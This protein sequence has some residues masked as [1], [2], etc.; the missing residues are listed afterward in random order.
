M[1]QVADG[2]QCAHSN[3]VVHRDVKPANIRL[4]PDG[5]VKILDFG[6]ARVRRDEKATR[7]TQQGDLIGTILYMSPE[8]FGGAD[9]DALCDIFAYGV[10]Y[11]EFLTGKH[12]FGSK[13]P[14]S[15]MFKITMEDPPSLRTII[16]DCPEALDRLLHR[17]LHKD[18]ELRYQNLGDLRLDA[19]P[20]IF[21][22]RQAR[23][24][25]LV[26][27]AQRLIE[28]RPRDAVTLVNDALN[29]DPGN[30]EA[31]YLREAIQRRLQAEALQPRIAA[32]L[33]TASEQLAARSVSQAVQTLESALKLDPSDVKVREKLEAAQKQLE[34]LNEAARLAAAAS[35]HT[36]RGEWSE[37]LRK[38]EESLQLDPSNEMAVK[39]LDTVQKHERAVLWKVESQISEGDF[40][41]AIIGLQSLA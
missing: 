15:V 9:A 28:T 40:G 18:R 31:R 13:D 8:Q 7:L 19:E 24:T 4:L 5:T 17:A 22:L 20:L 38:A 12:P 2:L 39:V 3:G 32:M 16:P 14:R 26:A 36:G 41:S 11:F 37:A 25:N 29:F 23:A 10:I 35:A 27:E 6:I 30:R 33:Q 34:I 1:D 21:E